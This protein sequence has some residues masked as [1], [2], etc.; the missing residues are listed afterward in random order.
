MDKAACERLKE[1]GNV[2]Y[3]EGRYDDAI[4]LYSDAVRVCPRDQ[5]G[6][7]AMILANRGACHMQQG[8][9]DEAIK[10]C[11][12][13]IKHDQQYVKAYHRRCTAYEAQDKWRLAFRDILKVI[14]LDPSQRTRLRGRRDMLRTKAQEE[15]EREGVD[16]GEETES[17]AGSEDSLDYGADTQADSYRLCGEAFHIVPYSD[18]PDDH[19]FKASYSVDD[20][21]IRSGLGMTIHP[22]FTAFAMTITLP[23]ERSPRHDEAI[24]YDGAVDD[25]FLALNTQ[26]IDIGDYLTLDVLHDRGQLDNFRPTA[27]IVGLRVPCLPHRYVILH[28][29]RHGETT[30]AFLRVHVTGVDFDGSSGKATLYEE[31]LTPESALRIPYEVRMSY[32]DHWERVLDHFSFE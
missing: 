18:L 1:A 24:S 32:L 9:Y 21:V 20:P 8:H 17:E 4:K 2:H 7:K 23:F 30:V 28:G 10:D 27:R 11:T 26:P 6:L 3:R 12:K 14:Q 22:S 15:R 13:S 5:R 25:K 31:E 16:E 29:H 19:P